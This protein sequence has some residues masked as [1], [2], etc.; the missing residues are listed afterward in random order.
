MIYEKCLIAVKARSITHKTGD[1]Y[2]FGIKMQQQDRN[3]TCKGSV[4]NFS[5]MHHI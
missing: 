2:V 5:K 3:E 4:I 1:F